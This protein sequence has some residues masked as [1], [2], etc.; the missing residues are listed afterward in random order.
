MDVMGMV[1]IRRPN[2]YGVAR[3]TEACH[4]CCHQ[5]RLMER[6]PSLYKNHLETHVELSLV[7][8]SIY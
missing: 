6:Y 1:I 7:T 5:V 3:C 4:S 2:V 8:L